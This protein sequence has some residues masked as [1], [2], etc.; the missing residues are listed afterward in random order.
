RYTTVQAFAEDLR[1]C[2]DGR[3][4]TARP[5]SVTYRFRKLVFRNR[6]A[7]TLAASLVA[8]L[9]LTGRFAIQSRIDQARISAKE[10]EVERFITMLS[11]KVERWPSAATPPAERV[12]DLQA[13]K[14]LITSDTMKSL[15]AEAPNPT[16]VKRLVTNL[17]GVIDR[18]DA[19]SAGD[20]Q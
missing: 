11:A 19:L 3:P 9:T 18:A 15:S 8:A 2:L 1:R 10:T 14:K 16:R 4:I 17:R 7:S 6:V 12:A 5:E 20:V 13:A